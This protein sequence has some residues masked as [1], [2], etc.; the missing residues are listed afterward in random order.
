MK[1]ELRKAAEAIGSADSLAITCHVSPD[2]DAL[3]SALGLAHAARAVGKNAIVSFGTPFVV[4]P[5]LEFLD[6]APLVPPKQFPEEPEVMVVFDAG[7]F[8]RL[9]EL[10]ASAKRAGTLVVVDHH[11]TNEGFGDV[12]VI[13]GSVAAS[14][15]LAV[16]LLDELGWEI[17]R[18][19]ATCLLTAIVTD[20]GRFQ[21]SSTSPETLRV[22]AR[23][24]EAGARPEEIGQRVY[25]SVA[26]AYLKAASIVLGRAELEEEL[27]LVWSWIGHEDLSTTGARYEDLDGLID[28]IRIAREAGVA[29]LLKQV[30]KGWKVSLRSRGE[31]DVGAIAVAHGGGGHHNAAG[32]TAARPLEEI[33]ESIRSGL[34]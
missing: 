7:S 12:Q 30:D 2:G 1:E 19:V 14:G 20:T 8:D 23:L 5:T 6:L 16:Y 28:D 33:I 22:A 24:V 11:V 31:V 3:G 10:G 9:V 25:E 27:S 15:Q 18:T 17:D 21:Y 26:F 13:D 34:R 29:V 4:P 32:F